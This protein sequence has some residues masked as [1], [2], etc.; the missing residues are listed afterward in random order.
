MLECRNLTVAYRKAAPTL[1]D[2]S[3]FV[4]SG[5][6]TALLGANGAGKTTLFKAILQEI[7]YT[8]RIFCDNADL[9]T[10]P[11]RE[12]AKRISLLP[13]QLP[14]PALSVRET[15]AL[16]LSPYTTKLGSA[17]WASVDAALARVGITDL[18]A[19]PVSSLSGGERQKT[20]LALLLTQDTP[21]LLLDEPTAHMDAAFIPRFYAI[22]RE[23]A[24]AG[25]AV[26]L[27]THD[28]TEALAHADRIAVLSGGTVAFCGT[29]A[30]ALEREIPEKYFSLT[31]YVA[32]RGEKTAVF[33]KTE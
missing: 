8:G 26:L 1:K 12:R 19:R 3:L 32:K 2:A 18:A 11:H 31:R 23:E 21:V 27:I 7:A 30:E 33:F 4:P 20:F 24:A 22:L 28:L 17:E 6:I 15:V 16:G 14:S 9:S 25:K 10:L 29:A 13:Q 5:A